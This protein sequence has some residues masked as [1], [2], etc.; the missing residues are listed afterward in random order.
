MSASQPRILVVDDNVPLLE[1]LVECL[2]M[3]GFTVSTARD[4]T[5]ALAVLAAEPLPAVV[6]LD[7]M[8]PGMDGNELAAA[9]RAD[10]RYEG[11]RLVLTTG[12][13]NPKFR[14]GVAADAILAK[15]FGVKELLAAIATVLAKR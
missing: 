2:H 8:M 14:A 3:E 5:S 15:P 12:H 7:L 1:N 9:I 4:G 10:P 6:L 13:A 11:I